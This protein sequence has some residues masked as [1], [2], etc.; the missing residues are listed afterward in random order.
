MTQKLG[1]NQWLV[2]NPAPSAQAAALWV[3]SAGLL[4]MGLQPILLGALLNENRVNFD[5][6]ALAATIEILAIGIGSVL[7]AFLLGGKGIRMKAAIFLVLTALFDHLTASAATPNAII[8]WRGMAGAAEGALVAFAIE[9]ITRSRHPGRYGGY[10]VSLQT[11][12][13][14]GIA[15]FLALFMIDRAGSAGGFETLTAITLATLLATFFLPR[16][17]GALPKP[18]DT[19]ASGLLRPLPILALLAIFLFF[20]FLGSL[21][22]FL[23]PLGADAGIP[24]R[25]VDLMVSAS[26]AAQVAGALLATTVQARLPFRPILV[27]G[28][29]IGLGIALLF[30]DKPSVMVFSGLTMLTGFVWLFVVPFQIRLAIDADEAR[31][32]ALLVPAAQLAGAALGPAGA[33]AFVEAGSSAPIALFAAACAL[34]STAAV[35]LTLAFSPRHFSGRKA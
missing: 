21:W 31:G 33:S 3:G 6:L 14:S 24:A 29:L 8:L 7:A 5:Q 34:A 32:A 13:Q 22:A 18:E 1:T 11:I 17:Y 20:M 4:I 27:I 16:S 10:F 35:L 19:S 25:T 26:L 9:L 30:A 15:I 12:A 23:E 2:G 28:G